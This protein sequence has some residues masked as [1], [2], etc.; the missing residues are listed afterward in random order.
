MA[1]WSRYID[2]ADAGDDCHNLSAGWIAAAIFDQQAG[3][4]AENQVKK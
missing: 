2:G 4:F 3:K 1:N